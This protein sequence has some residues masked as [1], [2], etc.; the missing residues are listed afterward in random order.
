MYF[1]N[2]LKYSKRSDHV[3]DDAMSLI[4]NEKK[5]SGKHHFPASFL[6]RVMKRG[7]STFHSLVS[8]LF[9]LSQQQKNLIPKK[10]RDWWRHC[11]K[12]HCY[13]TVYLCTDVNLFWCHNVLW[14]IRHHS[15]QC[16]TPALFFAMWLTR[17]LSMGSW[18]DSLCS[19]FCSFWKPKLLLKS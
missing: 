15:I 13:W 14:Q 1:K 8:R 6:C 19:I 3:T 7:L 11:W 5:L 16:W 9:L 18:I 17:S 2:E 4:C 12:R 10:S